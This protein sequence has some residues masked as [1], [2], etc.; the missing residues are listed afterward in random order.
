MQHVAMFSNVCQ[1]LTCGSIW[2]NA[3]LSY[4]YWQTWCGI[5]KTTHMNILYALTIIDKL[6]EASMGSFI[7]LLL[8][9]TQLVVCENH[10]RRWWY[11]QSFNSNTFHFAWKFKLPTLITSYLNIFSFPRPVEHIITKL[12]TK[13]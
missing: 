4:N 13:N 3:K 7:I 11:C 8:M 2:S 10:M 9:C 5:S 12:G 6:N 1:E